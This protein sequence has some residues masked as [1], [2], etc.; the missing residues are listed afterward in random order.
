[1]KEWIVMIGE[2]QYVQLD[3]ILTSIMKAKKQALKTQTQR[4]SESQYHRG[5]LTYCQGKLNPMLLK[6]AQEWE[7]EDSITRI[8]RDLDQTQIKMRELFTAEILPRM[9]LESPKSERK[10]ALENS[11]LLACQALQEI[12]MK[13]QL[14]TKEHWMTPRAPVLE[15]VK[16]LLKTSEILEALIFKES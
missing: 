3:C 12:R 13:V 8:N 9:P 4:L 2:S 10:A 1:M 6:I 5:I 11:R 16:I 7:N 15:I 14:K